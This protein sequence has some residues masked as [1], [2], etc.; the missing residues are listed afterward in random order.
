MG[1]SG[2]HGRVEAPPSHPG[3]AMEAQQASKERQVLAVGIR[4]LEIQ[5]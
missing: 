3:T 2:R 5:N 1:C 4:T